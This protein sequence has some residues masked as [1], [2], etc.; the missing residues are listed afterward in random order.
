MPYQNYSAPPAEGEDAAQLSFIK[1]LQDDAGQVRGVL[2]A[3]SGLESNPF[4]QPIIDSLKA[5]EQDD[6]AGILLD[7]DGLILYH[8]DSSQI[9]T[10]YTGQ[11]SEVARLFNDTAPNATSRLVYYQPVEG[12]N[13]AV[14]ASI[15]ANQANQLAITIAANL[16]LLAF[17]VGV[18]ILIALRFGLRSVTGSLQELAGEA[19]RIAD[20]QLD[21]ALEISGEDE[22]GQL[23]LAFEADAR[24]PERTYGRVQPLAVR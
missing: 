21:Q 19:A 7:D 10:P 6:G 24:A 2:L 1:T 11:V 13:W 20:N 12:R 16:L 18:I 23:G 5:L 14:V 15:P 4:S 17:G 8:P 22:V 3:R 9:L